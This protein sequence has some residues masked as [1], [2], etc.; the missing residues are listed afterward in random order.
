MI[1]ESRGSIGK[2]ITQPFEHSEQERG[3]LN[4][5]F[6]AVLVLVFL[7][8]KYTCKKTRESF[9]TRFDAAFLSLSSCIPS[10]L[11]GNDKKE[12][13]KKDG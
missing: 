1:G 10:C 3:A 8:Q 13:K 2:G 12:E 11:Q 9:F 5:R 7:N 4:T 6:A